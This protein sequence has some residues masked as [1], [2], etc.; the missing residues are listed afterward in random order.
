VPPVVE[1]YSEP[2]NWTFRL[3]RSPKIKI[4]GFIAIQLNLPCYD[5]FQQVGTSLD[6]IEDSKANSLSFAE[7]SLMMDGRRPRFRWRCI[8]ATSDQTQLWNNNRCQA[9]S[10]TLRTQN[11]IATIRN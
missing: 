10:I 8:E 11:W 7:V 6:G 4:L 1:V 5:V 2:V 9:A 3:A